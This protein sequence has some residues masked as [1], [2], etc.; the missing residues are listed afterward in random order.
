MAGIYRRSTV[1]APPL[2]PP[3][4]NPAPNPVDALTKPRSSAEAPISSKAANGRTSSRD[5]RD[6]SGRWVADDLCSNCGGPTQESRLY[7]SEKCLQEELQAARRRESDQIAHAL[8]EAQ[9][10]Q[11]AA[12]QAQAYQA[13]ADVDIEDDWDQRKKQQRYSLPLPFAQ[14]LTSSASA[15][16]TSPSHVLGPSVRETSRSISSNVAHSRSGPLTAS[17][18]NA[19]EL[20]SEATLP[21]SKRRFSNARSRPPPSD[22]SSSSMAS[23]S[24]PNHHSHPASR[25][26]YAYAQ[27][28]SA[29]VGTAEPLYRSSSASSQSSGQQRPN[30]AFVQRRSRSRSSTQSETTTSTSDDAYTT[31]PGTPS[32]AIQ[33]DKGIVS[34]GSLGFI[35]EDDAEPTLLS[36]PPSISSPEAVLL[37]L[38]RGSA[39]SL[40]NKAPAPAFASLSKH[41]GPDDI[42]GAQYAGYPS[43]AAMYAATYTAHRSPVL[44]P[45]QQMQLQ[46]QQQGRSYSH[47]GSKSNPATPWRGAIPLPDSI[48]KSPALLPVIS[49]SPQTMRFARR[50]SSTAMPRMASSGAPAVSSATAPSPFIGAIA[51]MLHDSNGHVLSA[52]SSPVLTPTS[53][54]TASTTPTPSAGHVAGLTSSSMPHGLSFF[55]PLTSASPAVTKSSLVNRP[56]PSNAP[57]S[58]GTRRATR[59]RVGFMTPVFPSQAADAVTTTGEMA[60]SRMTG[61]KGPAA[62]HARSRSHSTARTAALPTAESASDF[63][64]STS[65]EEGNSPD[66]DVPSDFELETRGRSQAPIS[67]F[68]AT[69]DGSETIGGSRISLA[70]ATTGGR[71]STGPAQVVDQPRGRSRAQGDRSSSRR[72]RSPPRGAAR[73][74]TSVPRPAT[75]N[76]YAERPAIVKKAASSP[77]Q[78]TQAR[79]PTIPIRP[80]PARSPA[81]SPR[82]AAPQPEADTSAAHGAVVHPSH[83]LFGVDAERDF[84]YAADPNTIAYPPQGEES[85]WERASPLARLARKQQQDEEQSGLISRRDGLRKETDD[86]DDGE[87]RGRSRSHGPARRRSPGAVR[88]VSRGRN[89]SRSPLSSEITAETKD[90]APAPTIDPGF[91]DVEIDLEC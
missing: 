37:N 50:P 16:N 44:S 17:A 54:G 81:L 80:A 47:T 24:Q 86:D 64:H 68:A 48:R 52:L 23:L 39:H 26:P 56:Q 29:N 12:V 59:E 71:G 43:T 90:T 63:A 30:G 42:S 53:S 33:A 21:F 70:T 38:Q 4:I 8:A 45:L 40:S 19:I 83:A 87:A 20:V 65:E 84:K 18:V 5:A 89:S 77:T 78:K 75:S 55:R 72:G 62:R 36:L 32:P 82:T 79:S 76:G 13:M 88:E 46:Q 60:Y 51:P 67:S 27:K 22:A 3:F 58:L 61:G 10:V 69:S 31:G 9:L 1:P 74:E 41:R 57:P 7:C 49:P 2:H 6:L 85:S 66:D 14:P 15:A 11:Q 35:H 91:D 34:G 73:T 25:S 28:S